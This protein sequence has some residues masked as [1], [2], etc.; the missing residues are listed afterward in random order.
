M[1]TEQVDGRRKPDQSDLLRRGEGRHPSKTCGTA[2]TQHGLGAPVEAVMS[3]LL[4]SVGGGKGGVGKS[5]IAANLA[6]GFAEL[7]MRTVVVDA[8]LGAANQ[9][10]L[11]GLDRVP[12]TLQALVD[13]DVATLD[14]VSVSTGL[15]RLFLV[16]GI[17]ALPGAA[18]LA[19]QVK[20]KIL[21]HIR[22]L[23]ADVVV[24][25]VGAGVSHHV[26]DFFLAGDLRVVV[27]TPQLPSLQN[28]YAFLKAGVH[29]AIRHEASTDAQRDALEAAHSRS[30][31]ERLRDWRRRARAVDSSLQQLFERVTH[32]FGAR[33][34]GNQ[35][36][37]PGQRRAIDALGRMAADFLELRA[38]VVG[39]VG[40]SQALHD[41]V[42]RRRPLLAN[43]AHDPESTAIRRLAEALLIEDVSLLRERRAMLPDDAQRGSHPPDLPPTL[44]E[45]RFGVP[46]LAYMRR[47]ERIRLDCRARVH[48]NG[49]SFEAT[50]EDLSPSGA[51]LVGELPVDIGDP[52]SVTIELAHRP[53]LHGVVRH[54][55]IAGDRCGLE[56]ER[57]SQTQARRVIDW[58]GGDSQHAAAR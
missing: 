26:V 43:R 55:S 12:S 51:L 6:I 53:T 23:D 24:I 37:A 30:E 10:T 56:L 22:R 44:V 42:T 25:D 32:G 3:P 2:L 19:H 31:T 9:Q 17:G 34:L 29:R 1:R 47:E 40:R 21:R 38:P 7:G 20:L 5:V 58:R 35:L 48:A 8:D 46:L 27:T 16:P 50:V 52:V 39:L 14:E 18:N 49:F 54:L 57:E 28:A 11:F 41:S 15:A 33:F 13:R 4:V 36:D 45:E